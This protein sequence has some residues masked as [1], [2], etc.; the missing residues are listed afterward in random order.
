MSDKLEILIDENSLDNDEKALP[1]IKAQSQTKDSRHSFTFIFILF[2]FLSFC[3]YLGF[4]YYQTFKLNSSWGTQQILFFN[5]IHKNFEYNPKSGNLTTHCIGPDNPSI[6]KPYRFGIYRCSTSPE[7]YDS[8]FQSMKKTIPNPSLIIFGGD[9]IAN[10]HYIPMKDYPNLWTSFIR[11][12]TTLYPNVPFLPVL[13]N[14][15]VF[16]IPKTPKRNKTISLD[17]LI[18]GVAQVLSSE[19]MITFKKGGYYYRDFPD[20]NI[21]FII[22]NTIMYFNYGLKHPSSDPYDQMSWYNRTV[23]E[24]IAKKLKIGVLMHSG[25][26]IFTRDYIYE[27]WETPFAHKFYNISRQYDIEFFFV[28]HSHYDMLLPMFNP[29]KEIHAVF[30]SSPAISPNHETNPGY[31]VYNMKNGRIK[32]YVQYWADISSNPDELK[33]SIEY[34]FNDAY[35]TTDLSQKSLLKLVA[36]IEKDPLLLRDYKYRLTVTNDRNTYFNKCLLKSVSKEEILDCLE[37]MV[38]YYE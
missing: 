29:N 3:F 36:N 8:A 7:T 6:T 38:P 14:H 4:L 15:D 24:G 11:E 33:W 28:G 13:G 21:R 27:S 35:K 18:P 9:M 19:E 5:D 17:H 31:R 20:L 32:N 26:N 22:L 1:P 2:A 12:I 16:P 37:K 25:S 10:F 30:L 23:A 34:T